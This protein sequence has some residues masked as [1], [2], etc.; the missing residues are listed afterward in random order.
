[1][2]L[3][4]LTADKTLFSGEIHHVTVPGSKGEF[5]VYKGHAAL[6]SSLSKGVVKV[7]TTTT[8]QENFEIAGGVIE[9][10]NNRIV[11]LA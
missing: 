2:F 5:Q 10:L 7:N 4:I 8:A 3:E 9:V 11:V 1:M 6:I